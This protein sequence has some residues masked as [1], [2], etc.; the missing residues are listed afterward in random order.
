M[1]NTPLALIIS[2]VSV[3]ALVACSSTSG[4]LDTNTPMQ[5]VTQERS[6]ANSAQVAATPAV[7]APDLQHVLLY[8]GAQNVHVESLTTEGASSKTSFD[9]NDDDN[10][11]LGFYESNLPKQ[12]WKCVANAR[13]QP[14]S[15]YSWLA[16]DA[17]Y[18]SNDNFDLWIVSEALGG[19]SNR[20]HIFARRWPDS[21]KISL[22]P[23]ARR[24]EVN[25]IEDKEYEQFYPGYSA[26]ERTTTYVS[27]AKPTTIEQYYKSVLL[28]P[29]WTMDDS[30]NSINSK[31]GMGFHYSRDV[32]AEH[33]FRGGGVSIKAEASSGDQTVVKLIVKDTE[34][35]PPDTSVGK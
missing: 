10:K 32:T 1:K 31:E 21:T 3:L 30:S 35:K 5:V 9:T 7:F 20:V 26:W 6:P 15:L 24:I 25:Y 17:Q 13:Y 8:P 18:T 4:S 27:A 19:N 23:D 34:I 16:R 14:C 2:V 11:V 29:D 33:R 28:P 22:Y 12:G